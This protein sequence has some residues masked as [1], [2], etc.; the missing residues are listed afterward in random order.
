MVKE[1]SVLV[2][3]RL[4]LSRGEKNIIDNF[5]LSLP[6]N[7]IYSLLGVNGAGK[8]SLAYIIMG[9][10]GYRPNKGKITFEGIDIT[11]KSSWQRSRL[12][13]SLAWQESPVFE[14]LSVRDYLRI[15][16]KNRQEY[17]DLE[18]CA[19]LM[20]LEPGK[21]LDRNMDDKLSGGERKRI[22]LASLLIAS[23]KLAVLDEP[24]SGIDMVSKGIVRKAINYLKHRGSTVLL[25]THNEEIASLSDRVGL[26][27][28]GYLDNEGAPKRIIE[29]FKNKCNHCKIYG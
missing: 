15:S 3:E 28:K 24:D 2:L 7:C 1:D 23:P 18:Y 21:Y 14:G 12:G 4:T 10:E 9:V 27:C 26:I 6:Q 29:L 20:G 25:I 19:T 17:G 5:S 16:T 22:E 8:S 13:I 11:R